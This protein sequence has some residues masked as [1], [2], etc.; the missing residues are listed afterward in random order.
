MARTPE[1]TFALL[2][3]LAQYLAAARS[4]T[5]DEAA[6]HFE[7][8]PDRIRQAV[9]LLWMTGVPNSWGDP[10]MFD[11]D[12]DA[13]EQHD[14]IEISY[15]PALA[16]AA[17]KLSPREAAAVLAGL[18]RL[19]QLSPDGAEPIE[20]LAA[21]IRAA[22]ASGRLTVAAQPSPADAVLAVLREAIESGA[23]VSF[24]YRKPGADL[25]QRTVVPSRLVMADEVTLVEGFD[26]DRGAGRTF[27]VD[28]ITEPKLTA[29]PAADADT[30]AQRTSV[31]QITVHATDAAAV[32][33]APYAASS[34]PAADGG[35]LLAVDV[36]DQE[37][38]LR[39][40]MATG[41]QARV[42]SPPEAVRALGRLARSALR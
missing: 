20:S 1:D 39:A 13:Y 29:R 16:D 14:R 21:R 42:V 25:E 18:A 10:T 32:A 35:R 11:F 19:S 34:E 31:G 36:W 38:V 24:N 3:P 26:P 30:S 4:V 5:V 41:G 8:S 6:A 37:A 28:R 33:L 23:A 15:L 9:R 22:T 2:A 27:R 17:V 12:F 40:V 7:V